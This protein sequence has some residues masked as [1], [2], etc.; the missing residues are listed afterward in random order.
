M[1]LAYYRT[2]RLDSSAD[3]WESDFK[4]LFETFP[5]GN[6]TVFIYAGWGA[7]IDGFRIFKYGAVK[8]LDYYGVKIC[9]CMNG[10]WG[11]WRELS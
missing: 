9:S 11:D 5:N 10:V 2:Y 1:N 7:R 4:T 3:Q 6:F 8:K